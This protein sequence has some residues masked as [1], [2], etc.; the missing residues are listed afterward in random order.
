MPLRRAAP[1]GGSAARPAAD[2]HSDP[3]GQTIGRYQMLRVVGQGGFGTVYLGYDPQLARR[4]AIK[5]PRREQVTWG[6]NL[7]AYQ[8]EARVVAGL[9]HPHIVPVYDVGQTADGRPYLISKFIEGSD[10][11]RYIA[12]R[13]L[14]ARAAA[15]LLLPIA[16]ALH[17][18]HKQG[19]VHRDI[20]PSNILLAEDSTPYLVDFGLALQ[21]KDFGKQS[22]LAGTPAYMS[23]EQ[24]RGESHLVDGRSDIFSLGAVLYHALTGAPPFRGSTR[25]EVLERVKSLEVRPP[26]QVD[27]AIPIELERICLKALAKR[28]TDRYNTARDMAEDLSLFLRQDFEERGP[29]AGGSPSASRSP[30]GGPQPSDTTVIPKGLRSFDVG[31]ADF[32]LSLLPGPVD[33]QGLPESIRFW[34]IRSEASQPEQTFR[35]GLLYGPSGCGKSS[36]IKAGLLPRLAPQVVSIYVEAAA[37]GTCELLLRSLRR[38]CPGL[39]A[40]LDLRGALAAVRRGQELP[41]SH[42]LLIVVDQ[43]EQCLHGAPQ[44]ELAAAVD[45]LGHCDGQRVQALLLVRDDFWMAASR[46]MHALEVPLRRG[47]ECRRRGPVS[48]GPCAAGADPVRPGLRVPASTCGRTV[49]GTGGIPGR[50]GDRAG[51]AA[52]GHLRS[53]GS[54]CRDDQ[55]STL[56]PRRLCGPWEALAVSESRFW[57][58][59]STAPRCPAYRRHQRA[60]ERMLGALLPEGETGLRGSVRSRSE[61]LEASGYA[62]RPDQFDDLIRLLVSDVRLLTPVDPGWP[63]GPTRLTQPPADPRCF[64]LSHDYLVPSLREWLDRKARRSW[65]GRAGLRLA[66]RTSLCSAHPDAVTCPAGG[67]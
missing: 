64:Q 53:L 38:R 28:A 45:V 46:F 56:E 58:R 19:L 11:S 48:V 41:A 49:Q 34:K 52:A 23:P 13:Q 10:L 65:R 24:A 29:A 39:S 61:L 22:P 17:Y 7:D 14:R 37:E 3:A 50:S 36:L 47:G 35:V 44:S 59:R 66:Q 43:F 42:R 63:R 12:G 18:A 5:V 60:A 21:D 33:R 6:E 4:V 9:D 1:P 15:E 2:D 20:K 51:R 25:L 8:A 26:R 16:E 27:D 62:G 57:K 31:D 30:A 55:G 32:F 40:E 54:V 67:S